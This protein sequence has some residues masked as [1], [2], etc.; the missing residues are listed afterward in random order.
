MPLIENRH[1]A[2]VGA[3]TIGRRIGLVWASK[4]GSVKLYDPDPNQAV[5]ALEW[6]KK[7]LPNM[8]KRQS[9]TAGMVEVATSLKDAVQDAWMIVE[10]TPE[11]KKLKTGILGDI[12]RLSDP[13]SIIATN[14]SSFKSRVLVAEVNLEDQKRVLNTHYFRPPEIPLVELMTC[15]RTDPKVIQDLVVKSREI[16][17]DPIVLKRE[18]TGFLGNRVWA[19]IKREIMAILAEDLGNPADIDKLFKTLFQA[20]LGPCEAMDMV[21]LNVVCDIEEQYIQERNLPRHGV[22][23]IRQK[24]IERGYLGRATARGLFHYSQLDKLD[25]KPQQSIKEQLIGAWELIEYVSTSNSDPTQKHYPLGNHIQG[26]L[27]YSSNGF[28]TAHL[29]LPGQT[30]FQSENPFNGS[31]RESAEADRRCLAYSGSFVVE[32]GGESPLIH[33]QIINCTFPN[34]QGTSQGRFASIDINGN[35][36]VLTLTPAELDDEVQKA[37]A[38]DGTIRLRWRK[39]NYKPEDLREDREVLPKL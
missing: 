36:T 28:M 30:P 37:Q 8:F 27:I 39:L 4:S 38:G 34:W 11:D 29:Q 17:L 26:M 5:Q 9:D 1:V 24:Y 13:Q 31:E 3:G 18:S 33:H 7:T 22:D 35:G 23:F 10:S 16:G 21:G 15:G 19:A 20:R 14:S 25:D 32:E 6:I 2:V 12:A